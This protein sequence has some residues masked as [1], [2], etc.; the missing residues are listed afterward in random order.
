MKLKK[1]GTNKNLP[2]K[3]KKTKNISS[4]SKI[5]DINKIN[6][7]LE[8]TEKTLDKIKIAIGKAK[9]NRHKKSKVK[10]VKKSKKTKKI[11]KGIERSDPI[12]YKTK[13]IKKEK[14][15]Q[16]EQTSL[17]K[18]NINSIKRAQIKN[19]EIKKAGKIQPKKTNINSIK[20]AQIE[21]AEIKKAGKVSIKKANISIKKP[22]EINKNLASALQ[23]LASTSQGL[24]GTPK[25]RTET[26]KEFD[27]GPSKNITFGKTEKVSTGISNL[28]KITL[29]G[30]NKN[31]INLVVG[32]TGTAKS[33]FAMQFLIEGIKKGEPCLFISFEE[34]K[35]EF[36]TNMMKLGWNLDDLE[37]K[38]KFSF[39][40]YSPKKVKT[41]LEE[42]GGI[43]ENL[44]LSKKISRIAIDSITSFVLLFGDD[45]KKRE[46]IL[47]L[48]NLLRKWKTTT[49]LTFVAN[50]IQKSKAS[51]AILEFESD[52]IILLYLFREEK[53]RN[54][55]LEVFKM[56]GTDH[57]KQIYQFEIEKGIVLSNKALIGKIT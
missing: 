52:S 24:T 22:E 21:K 33:I 18:T 14:N 29:G 10:A 43:I 41:M 55:Y 35:Q 38:R 26:T 8:K 23:N 27:F 32:E 34:S 12:I 31:S 37:K 40:Q 11:S 9:K 56:R 6:K 3:P 17:K 25:H 54:R 7:T 45:V 42:G 44:V 15:L 48:F 51:P 20:R 1:S 19:A 36:Y 4:I 30:F 46:A 5:K 53:Q 28:D 39:L 49:V 47:L 13:V 50:P 57:S 16:P 2:K